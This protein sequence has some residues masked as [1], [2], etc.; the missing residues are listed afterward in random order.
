MASTRL[1]FSSRASESVGACLA[2]LRRAAVRH[3]R[4]CY[5]IPSVSRPAGAYAGMAH[6]GVARSRWDQRTT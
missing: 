3:R 2:S 1:K 4:D 6:L 5:S